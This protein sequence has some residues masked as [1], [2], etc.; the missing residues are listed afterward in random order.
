MMY[1]PKCIQ[2]MLSYLDRK[3]EV[4]WEMFRFK[5]SLFFA[6]SCDSSRL[7]TPSF[8]FS[9]GGGGGGGG[10]MS[11]VSMGPLLRWRTVVKAVGE[12][13]HW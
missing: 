2:F 12:A 8:E 4:A 1:S 6:A 7:V 5:A 9:K 3:A 11:S 10:G 13:W